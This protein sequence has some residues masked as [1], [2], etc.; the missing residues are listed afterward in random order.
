MS[1]KAENIKGRAV[2]RE[3]Y[4]TAREVDNDT[5]GGQAEKSKTTIQRERER[6][7]DA[8]GVAAFGPCTKSTWVHWTSTYVLMTCEKEK[9]EGKKQKRI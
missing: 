9:R 8:H 6:T 2:G 4:A 3:R 7:K 1:V 5:G